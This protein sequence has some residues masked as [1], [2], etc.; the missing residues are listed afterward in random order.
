MSLDAM[1]TR[2]DRNAPT[3]Q[4][5]FDQAAADSI[6][7]DLWPGEHVLWAA[8]PAGSRLAVWRAV[9]TLLVCLVVGG[10]L[11]LAGSRVAGFGFGMIVINTFFLSILIAVEL[12]AARQHRRTVY[13]ITDRRILIVEPG[14][15]RVIRMYFGADLNYVAL[16]ARSHLRAGLLLARFFIDFYGEGAVGPVLTRFIGIRGGPYVLTL[17]QALQASAVLGP[18]DGRRLIVIRRRRNGRAV[19]NFWHLAPDLTFSLQDQTYV[20]SPAD[21]ESVLAQLRDRPKLPLQLAALAATGE[22]HGS[23]P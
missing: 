5:G 14:W 7:D 13:A 12:D 23:E 20:S 4:G 16:T 15:P 10:V 8:K 3:E 6:R 19:L 2:K 1:G 22:H 21:I 17:V 9:A 18:D 11:S